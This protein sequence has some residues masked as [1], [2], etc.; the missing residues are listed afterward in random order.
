LSNAGVATY[1]VG[2]VDLDRSYFENTDAISHHPHPKDWTYS[3]QVR[4]NLELNSE[5]V[6]NV[7]AIRSKISSV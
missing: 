3:S 1:E 6:V 7:L 2:S 5:G 4:E